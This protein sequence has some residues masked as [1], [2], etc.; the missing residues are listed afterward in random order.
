[1]ETGDFQCLSQK[2][3]SF[4]KESLLC[5]SHCADRKQAYLWACQT[6]HHRIGIALRANRSSAMYSNT[7]SVFCWFR[8][9]K[10][11]HSAIIK[12]FGSKCICSTSTISL[13]VFSAGFTGAVKLCKRLYVLVPITLKRTATLI[14]FPMSLAKQYCST[15][16]T[17]VAQSSTVFTA[18]LQLLRLTLEC[19]DTEY[20]FSYWLKG[21]LLCSF[22]K[23]WFCF[24]VY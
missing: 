9:W 15:L 17:Y 13:N 8:L 7:D 4:C 20:S 11:K 22:T 18:P 19:A 10:Q 1:M 3:L 14:S 21:V 16:S 24:G 12:G 6:N 2:E 5:C 23:S